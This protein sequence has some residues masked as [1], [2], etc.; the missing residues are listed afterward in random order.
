MVRNRV[1]YAL[2]MKAQSER[3]DDNAKRI[4]ALQYVMLQL[5]FIRLDE[6]APSGLNDAL[7]FLQESAVK[8]GTLA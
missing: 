4:A 7:T 3:Y 5:N 1:L 2:K 8:G 6:N